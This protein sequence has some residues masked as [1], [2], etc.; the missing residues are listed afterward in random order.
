[1]YRLRFHDDDDDNDDNDDDDDDNDGWVGGCVSVYIGVYLPQQR[2]HRRRG[3]R[4]R[5]AHQ[6]A[7]HKGGGGHYFLRDLI[8]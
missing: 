8:F 1:M 5:G 4:Q 6:G 3:Q 7:I 2:L